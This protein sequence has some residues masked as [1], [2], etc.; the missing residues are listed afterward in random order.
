ML[1]KCFWLCFENVEL[2]LDV[3]YFIV[4]KFLLVFEFYVVIKEVDV[5][6]NVVCDVCNEFL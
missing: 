2:F 6:M 5:V 4:R 3:V 1:L